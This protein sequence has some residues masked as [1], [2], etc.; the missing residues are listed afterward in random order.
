MRGENRTVTLEGYTPSVDMWAVGC[1][2]AVVLTGMNPFTWFPGTAD[3]GSVN[4]DLTGLDN[5]PEWQLLSSSAKDFVSK[6]IV[7]EEDTRLTALDALAHPWF[8][9]EIYREDIEALYEKVTLRRN[10]STW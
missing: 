1:V 8:T 7:L 3:Q 4:A 5:I 6:L 2:T 9:N 10:S